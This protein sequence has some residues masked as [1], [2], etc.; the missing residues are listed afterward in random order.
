[1]VHSPEGLETA[2]EASE[3]LFGK[4]TEETLKKLDE[5]TFLSVFEGVPLF[6]IDREML[7]KGINI[8][9]LLG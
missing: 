3:I 8:V 4:G 1:M 9:D 6:A 5:S 7:K 2:I